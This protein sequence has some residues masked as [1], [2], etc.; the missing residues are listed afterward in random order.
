[1]TWNDDSCSAVESTIE[2]C[3]YWPVASAMILPLL[4]NRAAR[5]DPVPLSR[6]RRKRIS[7]LQL[8]RVGMWWEQR[9]RTRRTR[10]NKILGCCLTLYVC[11]CVR[12][13]TIELSEYEFPM[14]ES[15]RSGI[16]SCEVECSVDSRDNSPRTRHPA[17]PHAPAF[18]VICVFGYEWMEG[19]VCVSW[20][21]PGLFWA[22]EASDWYDYSTTLQLDCPDVIWYHCRNQS[23]YITGLLW[24]KA[25]QSNELLIR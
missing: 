10:C 25:R 9:E 12:V 19:I 21:S 5:A 8:V 23:S 11:M 24:S 3:L 14:T 17:H 1:M 4:S 2:D 16:A 13:C 18:Y 7:R 15:W 6:L 20:E 22:S